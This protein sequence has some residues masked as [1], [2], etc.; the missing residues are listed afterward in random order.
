[1]HDQTFSRDVILRNVV[2]LTGIWIL[3]LMAICKVRY[4]TA[5]NTYRFN[6]LQRLAWYGVV[7]KA[8]Q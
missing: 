5:G 4:D 1:M 2:I 6:Q 7:L 8:N 3:A